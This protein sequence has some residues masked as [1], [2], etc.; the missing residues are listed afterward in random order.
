MGGKFDEGRRTSWVCG[1][2]EV[3]LCEMDV[4]KLLVVVSCYCLSHDISITPSCLLKPKLLGRC[5]DL[6]AIIN[7]SLCILE[8]YHDAA[9]SHTALPAF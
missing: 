2:V 9:A 1:T 6:D 4:L 8:G 3:L 5:L 7:Q